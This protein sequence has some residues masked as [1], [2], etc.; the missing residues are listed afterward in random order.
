MPGRAFDIVDEERARGLVVWRQETRQA[1]VRDDGIAHRQRHRSLTEL[2]GVVGNGHQPQLTD[3]VG[4]VEFDRAVAFAVQLHEARI[5][6]DRSRR[7]DRKALATAEIVAAGAEFADRAVLRLDETAVV[8]ADVEAEPALT[9]EVIGRR[10]RHEVR[11]LEDALVD[12]RERQIGVAARIRNVD[13]DVDARL[14]LHRLRRRQR[15]VERTLRLVDA[16]PRQTDRAH[17]CTLLAFADTAV[18]RHERV[19]ARTPIAVDAD[20]ERRT[21]RRDIDEL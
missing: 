12:G 3:I 15:D 2:I 10:R 9:E 4:D 8:V 14:R 11:E 17:R 18:V 20:F 5:E 1:Q 19:D 6:R 7:D 13:R 21:L 16:D